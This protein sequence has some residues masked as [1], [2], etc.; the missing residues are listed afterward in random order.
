MRMDSLAPIVALLC[1]W[2]A[3]ATVSSPALS[4]PPAPLSPDYPPLFDQVEEFRL[5]NGML[6]LLLP[7]HDVPM[8]S[9]TIVVKVGNVDN[10][11]GATGLAHMFEHMAFKGTDRIGTRDAAAEKAIGDTIAVVG[12][13]LAG[14]LRGG[15]DADTTRIAVLHDE[16]ASLEERAAEFVVP[17]EF[18]RVY[19]GY[20]YDFNAYTSQDFTVYLATLPANNLE[21]W[22]LM[23]SE[24]LQ[25]PVFRE[26]YAELEVVKEERRKRAD[27][28]PEGM[29]GE[30]L[31]SL[32][33]S[34]HPYRFPTIGYMDDLETLDPQQSYVFWRDYYVPGNMV[35]ALVG[36]FD[37]A[38]AKLMIEDYFGDIPL[39]P[40]PRGPKTSEPEQ[41]AGRSGTHRQGTE[42]R[43]LMAF[44]GFSPEDP[45]R[46]AADLLSS[47]LTR[48]KTSRL[49]RRLDLAEGVAR[50]VYSSAAGGY[51]RYAGLFTIT[52]DLM[53]DA[54]NEQ[55]EQL[56]W[57]ELNK[58]Q[59]EPVTPDKLD[60]IRA[61]YRKGFVFQLQTNNELSKMLATKQA[62]KG[63]WRWIYRR[64]NDYDRI[65]VDEITTLAG[66]LFRPE[67]ASIVY[68]EPAAEAATTEGGRP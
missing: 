39:R 45:R 9:G 59:T 64:F 32:A 24:R 22:M 28:N 52:V 42:R 11:P 23:E 30:L 25:H 10:P 31:K 63:D 68:L 27:D 37:T 4:E 5:D 47:A 66:N 48:D 8:V 36:D 34:E 56:V 43:L 49:V 65:T 14:L 29:A 35:A 7:R 54:T 40:S 67:R 53:E 3:I 55:A 33:F 62:S 50:R 58:L 38:E 16:V 2:T 51:Q 1:V 44:P 57:E 20:T 41:T 26:F 17:M 21:V 12:S 6:F 46:L 13:E 61:S 15:A 60:E 19:D 18:P